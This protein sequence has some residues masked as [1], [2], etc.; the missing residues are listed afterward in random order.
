MFD[1]HGKKKKK[2]GDYQCAYANLLRGVRMSSDHSLTWAACSPDAESRPRGGLIEVRL[3]S[4]NDNY[5]ST[6]FGQ[7]S[8]S[9]TLYKHPKSTKSDGTCNHLRE[10][11][12][13][14]DIEKGQCRGC[15]HVCHIRR[16][17][18]ASTGGGN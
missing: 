4:A 3:A 12:K 11:S 6:S 5:G 2:K 13:Q 8:S 7:R 15:I 9:R 14:E 1:T 18:I 10:I 16:K 17:A